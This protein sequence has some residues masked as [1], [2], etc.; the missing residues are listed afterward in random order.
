MLPPALV[1]VVGKDAAAALL[2]AHWL[3]LGG[4]TESILEV[5]HPTPS[6][7]AIIDQGKLCHPDLEQSSV[8][9]R[10]HLVLNILS[11]LQLVKL[12]AR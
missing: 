5:D 12:W 9:A 2:L 6:L 3:A 7:C 1:S 4:S 8:S 10:P 11:A